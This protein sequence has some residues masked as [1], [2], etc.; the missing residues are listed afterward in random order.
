MATLAV[1]LQD[2]EDVFVEG[3]ML[4]GCLRCSANASEQKPGEE[5]RSE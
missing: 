2:G 4:D 5:E 3:R 1:F